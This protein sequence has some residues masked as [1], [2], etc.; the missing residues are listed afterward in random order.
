MVHTGQINETTTVCISSDEYW[1]QA[2]SED[3]DNG[4]IKNILSVTEETLVEP[5]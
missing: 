4:Y 1:R 2:S 3:H 5:K